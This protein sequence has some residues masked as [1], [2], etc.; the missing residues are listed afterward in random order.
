MK[1]ETPESSTLSLDRLLQNIETSSQKSGTSQK[2]PPLPE[3]SYSFIDNLFRGDEDETRDTDEEESEVSFQ[4]TREESTC[5]EVESLSMD[6]C[7]CSSSK[8]EDTCGVSEEMRDDR[9]EAD[10]K[11]S[12]SE[13]EEESQVSMESSRG[14]N[15]TF[16]EKTTGTSTDSF[17]S[18]RSIQDV[19]YLSIETAS[20]DASSRTRSDASSRTERV[21]NPF[22]SLEEANVTSVLAAVS[23]NVSSLEEK[24]KW[25]NISKAT[26]AND[27]LLEIEVSL[28]YQQFK[29]TVH[30]PSLRTTH[31]PTL[32][33]CHLL[34]I[35]SRHSQ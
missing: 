6:E 24:A 10:G 2:S 29:D 21:A 34:H 31:N 3:D 15:G 28:S 16:E 30:V 11:C 17:E 13:R 32:R 19:H 22:L 23:S 35:P 5:V 1:D 20:C 26:H 9:G 12:D 27:I 25:S 4:T 18:A 14:S 8:E 33:I 7:T